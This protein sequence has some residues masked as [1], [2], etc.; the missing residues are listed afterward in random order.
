MVTGR[1]RLVRL[2]RVARQYE[3]LAGR[4]TG[5]SSANAIALLLCVTLARL[6]GGS[7]LSL[8]CLI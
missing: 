5:S 8:A 1:C 6:E 3:G 4:Q 2:G 7:N